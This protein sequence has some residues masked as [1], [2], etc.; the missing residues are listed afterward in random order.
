[1]SNMSNEEVGGTS[2]ANDWGNRRRRSSRM[3]EEL[4]AADLE[5]DDDLARYYVV[6]VNGEDD[7]LNIINVV[8]PYYLHVVAGSSGEGYARKVK[9]WTNPLPPY[10]RLNGEDPHVFW[11]GLPMMTDGLN[12]CLLSG[13][14]C[15]EPFNYDK[16]AGRLY[17]CTDGTCGDC[18]ESIMCP[19][20]VRADEDRALE[21]PPEEGG[22]SFSHMGSPR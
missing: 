14:W 22:W 16:Y 1:M 9:I 15:A 4:E 19:T 7:L 6:K 21:L 11:A 3:Q 5:E 2:V 20:C 10:T 18:R 13:G 17:F 12:E 8:T